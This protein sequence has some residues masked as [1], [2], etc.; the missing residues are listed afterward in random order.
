[1]AALEVVQ[2][3]LASL[4]IGD[5]CLELHSNKATKKAVLDQLR[6][7]LEIRSYGTK[8]DYDKKIREI[9]AI[10]GYK[11]QGQRIPAIPGS[12]MTGIALCSRIYLLTIPGWRGLEPWQ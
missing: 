10:D 3:R 11:R 9:R 7:G 6:R 8:T 2:R 1:M 12:V 5:F 4:G